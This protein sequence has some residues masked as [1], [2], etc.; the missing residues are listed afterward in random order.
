MFSVFLTN[1]LRSAQC[2]LGGRAHSLIR[3][4]GATRARYY[5]DRGSRRGEVGEVGVVGGAVE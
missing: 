2:V 4:A 1:L 5:S 3:V